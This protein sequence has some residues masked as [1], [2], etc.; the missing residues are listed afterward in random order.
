VQIAALL[1][2][3]VIASAAT[4]ERRQAA[5]AL[6]AAH[7]VDSTSPDWPDQVRTLTSGRGVDVLLHV[8]GG[9]VLG[10]ALDLLAPF[11]R[12][13]VA[14]RAGGRTG[15]IPTEMMERFLY[16]PSLHQSIRV[17]NLGLYFGMRPAEAGAAL[18]RLIG[19]IIEGR[20]KV[21]VGHV[22]PLAAA[23]EAH[24]V[25]EQRRSVG[26]IILKPWL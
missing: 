23:A 15:V 7:A 6:G 8:S 4:A 14:G 11:G 12:L 17:F 16:R 10:Q 24:R 2:A 18:G 22:M 1:G 5:R 25:I 9:E 26:K 19:W 3:A 20:V 13:V 21:P